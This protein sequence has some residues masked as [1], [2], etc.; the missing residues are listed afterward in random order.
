MTGLLPRIMH[1]QKRQ[2]EAYINFV[3]NTEH[4]KTIAYPHKLPV[5][6]AWKLAGVPI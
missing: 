1:A 4:Y 3:E 6:N 2:Q 5:M